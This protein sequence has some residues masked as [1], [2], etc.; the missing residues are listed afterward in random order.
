MPTGA[1]AGAAPDWSSCARAMGE[2]GFDSKVRA[3]RR[4][5]RIMF[6]SF[7]FN[8][9]LGEG[10]AYHWSKEKAFTRKAGACA[11]YSDLA[12]KGITSVIGVTRRT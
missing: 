1:A 5:A 10:V 11:A 2:A 9:K 3:A 8:S 7:M 6:L 12:V 4:Q